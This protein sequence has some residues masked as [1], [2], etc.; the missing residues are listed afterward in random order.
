MQYGLIDIYALNIQRR[1]PRQVQPSALGI[2][3]YRTVKWLYV[4]CAASARAIAQWRARQ[5]AVRDLHR[6]NDHLLR[7]IGIERNDIEDVVYRRCKRHAPGVARRSSRGT[8][9]PAARA[10]RPESDREESGWD[11]AA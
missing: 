10:D 7:D 8:E 9:R 3:A 5:L 6:L 11:A 1:T 2:A 4:H